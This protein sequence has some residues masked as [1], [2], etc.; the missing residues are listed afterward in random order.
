M[1][2]YAHANLRKR[3]ANF[4]GPASSQLYNSGGGGGGGGVTG[5]FFFFL[6]KSLLRPLATHIPSLGRVGQCV[7]E[8]GLP[9]IRKCHFLSDPCVFGYIF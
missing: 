8:L 1:N 6:L 4:S 9:Q 5:N 2:P 3:T 7:W